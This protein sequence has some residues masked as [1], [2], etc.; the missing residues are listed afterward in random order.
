MEMDLDAVPL[1]LELGLNDQDIVFLGDVRVRQEDE[2]GRGSDALVYR[3]NWQ[4]IDIALKVLHP[5]LIEPDVLGRERTIKSFGQEIF[6]L[7]RIHHPNLCQLLGIARVGRNAALALEL[8]TSTLEELSIGEDRE[9]GL[10]LVGY[11][12]DTSAGIRYLHV[13][14]IL[15]RDLAPKNVMIKN[16]VAKVCDFGVAKFVRL[17]SPRQQQQEAQAS[18]LAMTRCPG[19]LAFMPPEALVEQ[20]DYDRPLDV[21]SLGVTLLAVLTGVMPGIDLLSAP[22]IIVREAGGRETRQVIAETRRRAAYLQ[23]LAD[24]HPL[25]PLILRCHSNE[26]SERP[27]AEDVHE[28]MKRVLQLF[29]GLSSASNSSVPTSVVRRLDVISEQLTLQART[30]AG[31]STRSDT[32]EDQLTGVITQNQTTTQRQLT[33]MQQQLT[34]TQEKVTETQQQLTS[35]QQEV[36]I[37]HNEQASTSLQ[38]EA[39]AEQVR[40]TNRRVG[41]VTERLTT[42]MTEQHLQNS[43]QVSVLN[44]RLSAT[45]DQLSSIDSHLTKMSSSSQQ[46]SATSPM[47]A[48]ES[49]PSSESASSMAS[50]ATTRAQATAAE[51]TLASDARR[52]C[53]VLPAMPTPRQI[54]NIK[55]TR[56]WKKLVV[57]RHDKRVRLAVNS[58]K[59]VAVW[60]NGGQVSKIE[61][62]SDMQ[63]WHRI[64]PPSRYGKISEP[65]LASHGGKLYMHCKVH[66]SGSDARYAI[67]LYGATE[68]GHA[69]C[70]WMELLEVPYCNHGWCVMHVCHDLISLLGGWYRGNSH[71]L[72]STY[73][74]L[75]KQWSSSDQFSVSEPMLLLP[76]SCYVASLVKL[77]NAMFIIGGGDACYLKFHDGGWI[78]CNPPYGVKLAE[79]A[80]CALSDHSM[81]ICQKA[82]SGTDRCVVHDTLSGQVYPLP[83]SPMSVYTP[84]LTLFNGT[85]VLSE[86]DGTATPAHIYTLDVSV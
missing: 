77:T 6:R 83:D 32:L 11:L 34:T 71:I 37:V 23:R 74:L 43:E 18:R 47:A 41:N 25:K 85:L 40:D 36:S 49:L 39:L 60:Y 67:L 82:G 59:L 4:G 75:N 44:D 76:Q 84:S 69:S 13:R 86:G 61:Q 10:K 26:P 30:I 48:S 24:D 8:L 73:S 55:K 64:D 7:S 68:H 62:T 66:S 70:Q 29:T 45:Q 3:L 57:R 28:E 17:A 78:A 20:P 53:N 79:S 72:V 54:A 9:D 33:A 81:V 21:F 80:A 51:S 27:T 58:D 65:S 1:L 56:K 5:V 16:G 46:V 38:I 52:P 19:T 63:T 50:T 12:C 31:L 14:G 2:L 22:A 42:T 35:A 15:H